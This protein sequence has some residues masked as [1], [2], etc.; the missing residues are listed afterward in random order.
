[1]FFDPLGVVNST[2]VGTLSEVFDCLDQS[3]K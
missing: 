2:V 3:R 1:M